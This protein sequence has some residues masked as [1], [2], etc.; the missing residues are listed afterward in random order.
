MTDSVQP[1]RIAANHFRYRPALGIVP[2]LRVDGQVHHGRGVSAEAINAFQP[3]KEV[4]HLIRFNTE[5]VLVRLQVAFRDG[6]DSVQVHMLYPSQYR[7]PALSQKEGIRA[8]G[9]PLRRFP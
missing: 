7:F 3:A 4:P 9:P 8:I 6:A 2:A 1:C 5:L